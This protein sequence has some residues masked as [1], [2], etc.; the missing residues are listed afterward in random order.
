[1]KTKP[2]EYQSNSEH[3]IICHNTTALKASHPEV[4]KLKR[5]SAAQSAHGNKIWRSSF[6]LIDYLS[7]YP[8]E[9]EATILEV[10]CGWGLTGIYL[11]KH[12]AANVTA[13]DIDGTV[14]PFLRLQ[15]LENNAD[16]TFQLG[17]FARLKVT[18]LESY[19]TIIGADICF[20]DDLVEPLYDFIKLSLS[21]GVNRI[22]IADPGR[23]PFWAL[24]DIAVEHLNGEVL[25]RRIDKPRKTEKF[26]L[27]IERK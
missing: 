21:A 4:R 20:W 8:P 3:T 22:I 7:T 26:I 19:D 14:E 13:L 16:V 10:G 6:V 18:D 24:C 5:H 1:M 23:P 2:L 15:A 9:L 11:A 25:T 27:S 12:Y 17:D